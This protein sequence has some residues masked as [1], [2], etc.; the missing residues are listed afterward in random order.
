MLLVYNYFF[1]QISRD[2]K[3]ELLNLPIRKM[4]SPNAIPHL[5]IVKQEIAD[6]TVGLVLQGKKASFMH[7]E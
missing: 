4:L 3:H 2:L 7:R 1:I 6:L 5:N